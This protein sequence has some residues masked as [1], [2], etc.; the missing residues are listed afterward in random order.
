MSLLENAVASGNIELAEKLMNLQ[1]RWDATNARKAFE[2]AL[3]AAKGEI[4]VIIRNA[5]GHNDKLYMDFAAIAKTIDPILA[6]HGL[7]YR[8]K[9]VQTEKSI[10]VTCILFGHGHSEETALTGGADTTGSKN[11]IQAIGLIC[12]RDE[13]DAEK[14]RVRCVCDL[15]RKVSERRRRGRVD[16]T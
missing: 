7:S 5:K 3:A 13:V 1:E 15:H 9:T 2:Q 4:P 14:L 10:T 11:A 6:R 8:F 16:G 12:R